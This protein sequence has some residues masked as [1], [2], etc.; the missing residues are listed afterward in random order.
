MCVQCHTAS[1]HFA[2]RRDDSLDQHSTRPSGCTRGKGSRIRCARRYCARL[3]YLGGS[4]TA[5]TAQ[6]AAECALVE[7]SCH[8]STEREILSQRSNLTSSVRVRL[9]APTTS[10]MRGRTRSPM[11]GCGDS[12]SRPCVSRSACSLAANCCSDKP[13]DTS[14]GGKK[15]EQP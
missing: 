1:A 12:S 2:K 11:R 6:A 14:A 13:G 9:S 4:Q 7:E 15:I 3:V 10:A 8:V 5:T